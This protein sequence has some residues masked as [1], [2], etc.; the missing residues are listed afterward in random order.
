MQRWIAPFLLPLLAHASPCPDWPAQRAASEITALAR[1]IARW[2][3]AYHNH[4]QT[5][6]ADEL[7]D[8]ARQRLLD[9]Q[10]CYPSTL[11]ELPGPLTGSAGS[12]DH[13]VP[14]TGLHKLSDADT[15]AWIAS[16]QN[17][18]IQ[19]KV[20]GVAVTLVYRNGRLQQAISRGN[21]RSGQDWSARVKQLPAVP[22]QLPR[23]LDAVLQGEL[24]WRLKQHVQARDGSAGARGKVAGAMARQQPDTQQAA[25]IGLFV[26]DWP[27]GPAEMSERLQQLAQLGFPD[28]QTH[29]HPLHDINQARQWRQH[30]YQQPQDFAT[31]GVVIRQG[32]RPPGN[33]WRA[34]APNWAIAWKHPAHQALAV[35]QRVEFSIGRS[36]RITPILHLQPAD[37]DERRISRVALGSLQRWQALDVHPGDQVAISLAGQT[38]PR[39]DQVIWRSPQRTALSIPRP[40]DYHE[41]SCWRPTPGCQQQFQARL[42]W[43]SSRRGLAMSGIGPNTWNAL[44]LEH[45]LDWL[46]LDAKALQRLPGIGQRRAKQLLETF[47]QARQRP[48]RQWLD[49]LGAPSGYDSR[50]VTDWHSLTHRDLAGWLSQPGINRQKARR[51]AAFFHHPEVRALGSQLQNEGIPA[52][53][54]DSHRL[55]TG[56]QSDQ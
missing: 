22:Q 42:A 48:L 36:G 52:F 51:L 15:A 55:T 2:D 23:P 49:A 19:P 29:T 40:E 11:P 31:D 6:V 47:A 12:L 46:T 37:L 54:P 13:P 32:S 33:R 41:L 18:W 4:G 14:Q 1:Q 8:Q 21:G 25:A 50:A 30:W 43:L 24:Y 34:E 56:G 44:P 26:W 28:S 27:D 7:Y 3:D 20:D 38:I 10:R 16:R 53:Q 35:V 39:L 9:W 5:Q 17:L 45:L